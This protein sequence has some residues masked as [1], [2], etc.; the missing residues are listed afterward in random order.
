MTFRVQPNE[1]IS[2]ALNTKQPGPG[3]SLGRISLDFDYETAVS[4]SYQ[5]LLL[6]A[7]CG[8]QTLFLRRDVVEQAWELLG[9]ILRDQGPLGSYEPGELGAS[10][11]RRADPA[12][13]VVPLAGQEARGFPE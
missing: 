5:L 10:R 11:S 8:D 12:K 2:I 7:M 9:P 4:D 6:E 13:E 3:L 1:G